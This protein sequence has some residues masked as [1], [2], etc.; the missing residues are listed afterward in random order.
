M[1]HKTANKGLEIA[2]GHYNAQTLLSEEQSGITASAAVEIIFL[3]AE[4]EICRA[5]L[6]KTPNVIQAMSAHTPKIFILNQGTT[7]GP[8]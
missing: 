8:V 3:T 4:Q 6:D 5:K 7:T 1:Q 2:A